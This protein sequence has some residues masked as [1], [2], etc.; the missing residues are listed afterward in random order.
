M[1]DAVI[2]PVSVDDALQLA[3][4]YYGVPVRDLV[5]HRRRVAYA[6]QVAY[7]LA[8]ECSSA[9]YAEIARRIGNRD[10]TTVMYGIA[11][12]EERM[13]DNPAFA[14]RMRDLRRRLAEGR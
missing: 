14:S 11:R 12:I 9:S 2:T 4:Q 6:R 13:N 7:W 1:T 8:Y 10:H 5:S 3:A